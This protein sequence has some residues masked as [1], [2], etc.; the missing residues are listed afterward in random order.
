MCK[1]KP[2]SSDQIVVANRC[3][4]IA[5]FIFVIIIF[6]IDVS[7]ICLK[8]GINFE[9]KLCYCQQERKLCEYSVVN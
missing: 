9:N 7:L 6:V 2:L 4:S 5:L 1:M 3:Y 8:R